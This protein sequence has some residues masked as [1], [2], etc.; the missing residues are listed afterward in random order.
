MIKHDF[1]ELDSQKFLFPLILKVASRCNLACTYCHWFRD[2]S[3]YNFSPV[4]KKEIFDLLETRLIHYLL[5]YY[6]K[7]ELSII[8][9]GGEP[10]LV[11]KSFFDYMCSKLLEI[12]EKTKK[13]IKLG[14]T[15]NGVLIDD[16]WCKIFKN[17]NVGV[18]VSL[19]G[20]KDIN[21]KSR[22]DFKGNGSYAKIVSAITKI[23]A[24]NLNLSILSVCDPMSDPENI[25][26]H[27]VDKLGIKNFDILIPNFNYEDKKNNKVKSISMFYIK[28][29][30][31]W[32]Y[33]YYPKKI[34]IKIIES[35]LKAVL[36]IPTKMPGIGKSTIRAVSITPNGDIQPHD[37]L[38]IN[39]QM[40]INTDLTLYNNDLSD[41][42]NNSAWQKALI[43]SIN[44]PD[45]CKKCDYRD[46]CNGGNVIHRYSRENQ[47]N[48]PSIY[49][50]D[51]KIIY[52]H[53]L[54]QIP[55]LL[56]LGILSNRIVKE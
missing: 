7:P 27:F 17:Y 55:K 33:I 56:E 14:V 40:S 15:T 22:I 49:C 20:D 48:N 53:I 44:L 46:I 36:Q 52:Q 54:D 35:F 30:N 39:N 9:H 29:F 6:P 28:L 11:K 43:E 34:K 37:V 51:L 10:L 16:D 31:L 47:Y 19:D 38:R 42:H 18:S 23:Q 25:C 1:V 24:N 4:I 50:A 3:V 5:N 2:K 12:G 13:S 45:T 21:D 32:M 41:I 8:F 26:K